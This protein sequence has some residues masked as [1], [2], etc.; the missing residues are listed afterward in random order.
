MVGKE[1]KYISILYIYRSYNLL[2]F[3]YIH[4]RHT[5]AATK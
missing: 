1:L 5:Q 3:N 4:Y 2:G